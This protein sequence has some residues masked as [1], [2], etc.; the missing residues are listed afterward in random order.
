MREELFR[1]EGLTLT[2]QD[3]RV[4]SNAWFYVG[5]GEITGILG[6]HNSGRRDLA[7]A[8][9]GMRDLGKAK[10]YLKE[11]LVEN[12]NRESADKN[13]LFYITDFQ[14]L[15]LE[16]DVTF[17]VLIK[18]NSGNTMWL[19]QKQLHMQCSQ[20][21]R[22]LGIQIPVELAVKQLS[23]AEKLMILIAKAVAK[24]AKLLVLDNIISTLNEFQLRN[25]SDLFHR[26]NSRGISI[27]LVDGD[28]EALMRLSENIVVIREGR[29]AGTCPRELFDEARLSTIMVGKELDIQLQPKPEMKNSKIMLQLFRKPLDKSRP[30]LSIHEGAFTGIVVDSEDSV[31]QLEGIFCGDD[32]EYQILVEG[33]KLKKRDLRRQIGVVR[34]HSV[35][36]PNLSMEENITLQYQKF[37]SLLGW[38][39]GRKIK[40]A[41][42]NRVKRFYYS[43]LEN[44]HQ[45]DQ[46][47]SFERTEK[48]M[49]EIC[50]ML[51]CQPK[52]LIYAN[53]VYRMGSISSKRLLE[54]MQ[55]I[56]ETGRTSVLISDSVHICSAVCN[57][58]VFF[59][60]NEILGQFS[61]DKYGREEILQ[62][63]QKNFWKN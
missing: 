3:T 2:E 47:A 21:L 36:F 13:G 29:I 45:H 49:L 56:Q 8:I 59:K 39:R 40:I 22:E 54:K 35:I 32:N 28:I 34:E 62:F 9:C 15:F 10:V 23:Y 46:V 43:E 26:L 7:Q 58:I 57:D 24:N 20:L 5:V 37:S 52:V 44:M 14:G 30:M 25:F 11:Q 33:K 38:V 16:A 4:L 42:N 51:I 18:Q 31:A 50:R 19:N 1:V 41:M 61:T 17:N 63:Y 6:Q 55:E 53:P 27:V 60:D 12:W 48:K